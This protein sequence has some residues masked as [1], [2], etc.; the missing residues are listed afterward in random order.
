MS[1]DGASGSAALDETAGS[2]GQVAVETRE[3]I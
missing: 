1:D 3:G 2:G